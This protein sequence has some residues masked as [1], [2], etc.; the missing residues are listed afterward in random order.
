MSQSGRTLATGNYTHEGRF[1][2]NLFL[3]GHLFIH[4]ESNS[5]IKKMSSYFNQGNI[6]QSALAGTAVG[7][8]THSAGWGLL[9]AT[10]TPLVMDTFSG[11]RRE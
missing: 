6:G 5:R 3:I 8:A 2:V 7:L 1:I 9:A 10:A 11:R 4:Y